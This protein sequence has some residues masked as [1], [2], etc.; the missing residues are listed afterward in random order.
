MDDGKAPNRD[1]KPKVSKICLPLLIHVHV[2]Q[3]Q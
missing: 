3:N 2:P 1:S